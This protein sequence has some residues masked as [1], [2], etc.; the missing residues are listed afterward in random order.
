MWDVIVLVVQCGA[1]ALLVWGCILSIEFSQSLPEPRGHLLDGGADVVSE[2]RVDV[3][4]NEEQ[5][6]IASNAVSELKKAA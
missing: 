2:L 3:A 5:W 1:V 4:P 6:V